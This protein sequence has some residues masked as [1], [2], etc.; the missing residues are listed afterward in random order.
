MRPGA[1]LRRIRRETRGSAVIE[2]AVA[3]P[4]L[5]LLL[6]GIYDMAHTAY[7]TSI[8]HGAVGEAARRDSLEIADNAKAD[9][10]VTGMV[11]RIA[12]GATVTFSRSSYYDFTDIKR[13]EAWTDKNGN[14][15]CDNGESYTD[16]NN[17]GKWD[18]DIGV[19]GNGG[20]N[21]VVLYTATVTYQP[22]FIV[23]FVSNSTS[24]RT[25]TASAVHK[26]QPFALQSKYGSTART[27][28]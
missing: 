23:P 7:L 22:V 1:I 21:D 9:A 19:S 12:P 3:C 11:Q 5:L 14:S 16:E 13:A 26:N 2:F 20:A 25:L 4:V 6:I 15:K 18:A 8:L 24:T 17:N 28:S 10:Y 27:C